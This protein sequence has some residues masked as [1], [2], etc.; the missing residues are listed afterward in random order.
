V[1]LES[2]DFI[3]RLAALVP[4]PRVNLTGVHSVFAPNSAH[5][6][7]VT[8]AHRGKG[9]SDQAAA[10]TDERTAAERRGSM[11]WAQRLERV[12]GIDIEICS[13]C[14][15][16]MRIIACVEDAVVIDKIFTHLDANAA[17]QASR[18]PPRASPAR[19]FRSDAPRRPACST[20]LSLLLRSARQPRQRSGC[21]QG[22]T[23][24]GS[25]LF[26]TASGLRPRCGRRSHRSQHSQHFRH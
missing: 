19:A 2:L 1:L 3:A 13:V 16:A 25:G 7:R 20:W 8:K 12:F 15:G 9:A 21:A 5:V 22:A 4:K 11:S 14:A 17:G 10:A 6:A 24:S 23:R 18:P 26:T